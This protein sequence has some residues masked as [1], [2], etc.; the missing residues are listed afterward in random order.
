[1]PFQIWCQ[2][3]KYKVMH[4]GSKYFQTLKG[5]RMGRSDKVS[6]WCVSLLIHTRFRFLILE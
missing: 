4:E 3:I 5:G 2:M 1:M 6:L